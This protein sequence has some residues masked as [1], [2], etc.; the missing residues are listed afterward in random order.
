MDS[1]E[2]QDDL[3]PVPAPPEGT[4]L[5]NDR[6]VVRT[7]DRHRVIVVAGI[8]LSQ[9][10]LGDRMAE[11]NAMVTL[12]E[13][14]WADQNDVA[15]AFGYSVRTVR[16]FQRRFEDGGL[17][18]LGNG[19]GYPRGRRRVRASRTK[20]IQ[21]LKAEGHSTREIARRIGI[22]DT[23]VHKLLRSQRSR[24]PR[25]EQTSLP[26]GDVEGA[27]PNL[28]A[29]SASARD[30]PSADTPDPSEPNLSVS[31]PQGEEP[32]PLSLDSDPANRHLDR[33]LACV[34]LLDDA[35]PLFRPG[36]R[37]PAAGVLL[38]LPALVQS[39]VFEYARET[40]HNLG[41]A[42]YGLRTT[43]LALLLMA[44]IRIKRP[45]GLKERP[46]DDFGRLLGLDRAPEVKTLRRKLMRLAAFGHAAQFGHALAERRVALRGSVLG[47]LYID[48]H[49]R[50]YHGQHALPKT[51]VARM[52]LSMPATSDY[53]V[54]DM[55]GDPLFVVTAEANAGLVK[56]LPT[57][58]AEI[59]TLIGT[60]RITV[61]F[62]RGGYS[63][64]LFE[65]LIAAGFDILTYRKGRFRRI[66][67]K[68]FQ[69]QQAVID[70]REIAY[71][72]ADQVVLLGGKLR[73]RQV[74]R[75]SENGHQTPILTSRRDLPAIE[76][77]FRM[78]ERWRQENF[79]KYLREEY[80]LDALVDYDVVPDDPTREVPNPA[81]AAIDA[82]LKVARAELTKLYAEYGQEA[83]CNI[84]RARRTMRGFKIAKSALGH[85]VLAAKKRIATLESRRAAKPKRVPVKDVVDG[86]IVKLAPEKK[87]LTNLMKMVAYQ[88]ES[89]LVRLVTPHYRRAEDE[90]R[91]LIQ[92]A[93]TSAADLEVGDHELHVIIAPLSSA[94]RT[95]AI[96]ALCD[97][98]TR[99]A[100]TFPG[101]RLRLHFR[102]R[103]GP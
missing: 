7:Q 16:R 59:R 37:I 22:S 81:R 11:A 8:V 74:T 40:F 45:E 1:N 49:V 15:R 103:Q 14:G 30:G 66:A 89:D 78:F 25:Y 53:W 38:A 19:S 77:A 82:K 26:L 86:Q 47:F 69:E 56:M 55:A 95:R 52:R 65:K 32:L 61:V 83:L 60:R 41:P 94:H 12:I 100:T 33:M 84:E 50:V 80:A 51:H 72:L 101:S 42:F 27:N 44:L 63:P 4:R 23:A 96:A 70:G 76:V 58:L 2:I 21:R 91:T 39:G 46:P 54:N 31:P 24:N 29:F 71:T 35:A 97:E 3:F 102:I 93:L 9:Y 62:D 36:T 34:G 85:A 48:G 64:K 6:C 43:I 5:I 75:L 20:L 28:S 68:R 98:L 67:R 18:A 99:T 87:L 57:V 17:S 10:V 88:A 92:S 90:G 13:Q 79:F 73:L